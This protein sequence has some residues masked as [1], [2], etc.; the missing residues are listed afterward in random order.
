MQNSSVENHTVSNAHEHL[1]IISFSAF[2]GEQTNAPGKSLGS[3]RGSER[4]QAFLSFNHRGT[5]CAHAQQ[6]AM[7][8]DNFSHPA[9]RNISTQA[10]NESGSCQC[11]PAET[12]QDMAVI[13]KG[14]CILG[15]FSL[16]HCDVR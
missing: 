1:S 8:L 9:M 16:V 13:F 15:A 3:R 4:E 10:V 12:W 14:G 5:E 2:K 6:D 7:R 11:C